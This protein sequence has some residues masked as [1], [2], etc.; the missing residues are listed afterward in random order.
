M[1]VNRPDMMRLSP[2]SALWKL[3]SIVVALAVFALL[4]RSAENTPG[5]ELPLLLT[6]SGDFPVAE[7]Q[8]LPERQQKSRTGYFGDTKAFAPVW[9]VFQPGGKTPEVDFDKNLVVFTRN[10]DF[11][12]HTRIAG[13]KL[14][15]GVVDIIAIETMTSLPIEHKVAMALAV[16]P[17]ADVKYIQSGH[18]RITVIAKR[19]EQKCN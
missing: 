17:R 10:V 19:P 5:K 18:E 15:D 11:Y 16:I 4:A 3:G 7:L 6:W 12:N 8:R 2:G 13:V 14:A 9:H 1:N